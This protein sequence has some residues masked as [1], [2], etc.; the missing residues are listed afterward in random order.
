[1][2]GEVGR[3]VHIFLDYVNYTA[4]EKNDGNWMLEKLREIVKKAGIREVHS[5]VEEFDGTK[6]PTGYA[7]VV[8]I[9]ES[10][11]TAHCYSDIG[12]LA[13]DVFTCGNNDPQ[14]VVNGLKNLFSKSIKEIR[15]VREQQIDRFIDR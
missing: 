10:H 9:D 15:L 7:A 6:S 13:I 12:L 14:L 4:P 11:V 8:L 5:H 2:S 3:G 1:M